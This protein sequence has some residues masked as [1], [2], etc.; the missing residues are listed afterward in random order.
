MMGVICTSKKSTNDGWEGRKEGDVEIRFDR[1]GHQSGGWVG[2]GDGPATRRGCSERSSEIVLS[3]VVGRQTMMRPASL[4]LA[5][6]GAGRASHDVIGG[7]VDGPRGV[8]GRAE[9]A[10]RKRSRAKD[11]D[12]LDC[13]GRVGGWMLLLH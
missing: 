11:A 10:E 9:R 5:Q 1:Q 3:V 6:N 8:I 4:P 2:G 12:L 13:P 7:A